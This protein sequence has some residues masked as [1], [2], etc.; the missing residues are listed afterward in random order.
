MTALVAW[1]NLAASAAETPRLRTLTYDAQQRDWSE[2]PPPPAGTSEG[3]LYVIRQLIK[4][5]QN[6]QA[7]GRI[8]NFIKK[9]GTGDS[10]YPDVLTA[11]AAALVGDREFYKAH[12]VLQEF[13]NQFTGMALTSEAI[14]LEFVVA[15]AF[16]SGEKRKWLGM[17]ILDGEELGIR[18]L[19]QISAEFPDTEFAEYALKTKGDHL[20]RKGDH[21]LAELEYSRMARD[22]PRSRYQ[23]FAVRRSADAALASF[24]GIEYDDAPLI[25][26]TDRFSDYRTR[27]P[28]FADREGVGLILDDIREKRGEKEFAIGEYYERTDHL[29]SAVFQYQLVLRLWPNTQAATKAAD[30]LELLGVEQ[31]V[32]STE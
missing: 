2:T 31:A 28:Q 21:S 19:D 10:L 6:R 17:A 27:Y 24:R 23:Q 5:K 30:R 7:L 12:E 11:K 16:L 29:G 26:A 4:E 20:F 8:K 9:Y 18:I 3:D 32:A 15:E 22:Y 14:R 13:L 25:E 1:T